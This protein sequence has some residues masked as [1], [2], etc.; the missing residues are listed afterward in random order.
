MLKDSG[1][2][3]K[4]PPLSA[5]FLNSVIVNSLKTYKKRQKNLIVLSVR[6]GGSSALFAI[7]T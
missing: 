6:I 7:D 1:C 4:L 2:G 3:S 5:T